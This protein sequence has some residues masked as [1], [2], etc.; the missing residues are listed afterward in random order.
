MRTRNWLIAI[1]AGSLSAF[2]ATP[3]AAA[4]TKVVV[5]IK[6]LHA[7]VA[8]VMAG[9]GTPELLVKGAASP[10]TYAMKPSDAKALNG[11]DLFFRMSESVEPFTVKVVRALPK[12]VTVVT[13]QDAPG[14]KLLPKRTGNTFEADVHEAAKGGHSKHDHDDD[15]DKKTDAPDG[16]AWLNPDNAKAMVARIEQAL[17]AKYP[18]NAAA[19]KANAQKVSAD[20]DALDKELAGKLK[21]I[22]GKPYIVFH[23]AFQ[24]LEDRYDL[25]AVGSISISPDVPPSA[26]RLSVL[27]KKVVSLAAACVFA[28]PQH[29]TRLVQNLVEGTSARTGTLDAEALALEPG[30]DLYFT[31]M[32]RLADDLKGC[33]DP[34][35]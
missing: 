6:P 10:H 19:F 9:V 20:I 8:G 35:A 24:Y 32:R 28:E 33:L 34:Q 17:G 31:M 22:A 21:P 14:M 4:Q 29:D 26:K 3:P 1:L 2:V 7:L 12:R 18:A 15:H 13:L 16:H 23:D 27:R 30:P 25:N 11:A 5:S